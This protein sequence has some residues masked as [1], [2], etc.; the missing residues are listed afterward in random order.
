MVGAAGQLAQAGVP[1][2]VKTSPAL[3]AT[4]RGT[5]M[6]QV[7]EA[8]AVLLGRKVPPPLAPPA[9]M[10]IQRGA[11]HVDLTLVGWVQPPTRVQ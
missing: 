10:L 5:W 1:G 3:S 4:K 7:A 8:R 2:R 11:C 6:S 9:G